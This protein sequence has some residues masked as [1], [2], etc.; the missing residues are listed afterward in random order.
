M[1]SIDDARRKINYGE[2]VNG[3]WVFGMAEEGSRKVKMF[4]VEKKDR[5]S[6]LS[7]LLEHV[8]KN[9]DIN[10]DGWKAFSGLGIVFNDYKVVNHSENFINPNTR[11][12]TQLIGCVL[13]QAKLKIVTSHCDNTKM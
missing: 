4:V 9:S 8:D 6:L 13:G 3:P 11:C 7:L 10:S 1:E 2:R 5:Y 12:Q